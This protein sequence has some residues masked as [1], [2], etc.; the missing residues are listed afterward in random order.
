MLFSVLSGDKDTKDSDEGKDDKA[1]GS[2]RFVIRG[3]RPPSP[4]LW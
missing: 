1:E 4:P 3:C 2:S